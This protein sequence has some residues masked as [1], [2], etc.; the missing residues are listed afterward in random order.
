MGLF[1]DWKLQTADL[2]F[3]NFDPKI[4]FWANLGWFKDADSYSNIIFLNFKS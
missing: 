3:W 4:R 2:D 1:M